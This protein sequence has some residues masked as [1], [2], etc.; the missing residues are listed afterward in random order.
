MDERCTYQLE[1]RGHM[2]EQDLKATSPVQMTA[3]RVDAVSMR[4]TVRTDQSGILG[5]IRYL[6][7]RGLALLSLSCD[8]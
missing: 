8:R 7:G 2:D 4:F 3:V 1:V 6:H 5:L